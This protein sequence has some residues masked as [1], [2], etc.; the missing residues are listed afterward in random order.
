M[1]RTAILEETGMSYVRISTGGQEEGTSLDTQ[2]LGCLEEAEKLGYYI[3]PENRLREVWSGAELER[4]VLSVARAAARTGRIRALFVHSPD[5]LSR[6]AY[7]ILMLMNEFAEHGVKLHFVRGVSGDTPEGQLITYIQGYAAQQERL[8]IAER[9]LRGKRAAAKEGRMP[10]GT[11]PGLFGYDYDKEHQ[12]RTINEAEAVIVRMMF[13][14]SAE[15]VATYQIGVR[16][17]EKGILTKKGCMWQAAGV[18]RVLNNPAYTGVQPYGQNRYR[19]VKG[20]KR[21]VTPRPPEEEVTLVG[22]SPPIICK[23]LFDRVQESLAIRQ[24]KHTPSKHRYLLTGFAKCIKCG[25]PIVGGALSRNR[26]YYRCRRN[27][28]AVA[29]APIECKAR[30]MYAD[31]MEEVVWRRVSDALKNPEILIAE[32][33]SHFET[34]GGNLGQAM[35]DLRGEILDLKTQQR[36][37]MELWQKDMIDMGLL[38]GQIAPLKSLCDEK[39]QDLR[40]LEEQQ[41]VRDDGAEME[42]RISELCQRFAEK[43]DGMDF[44]EKRATLGAFSVKVLASR[45]ELSISLIVDP[46]VV[47]TEQTWGFS[48][49]LCPEVATQNAG[50][51]GQENPL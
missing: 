42:G 19:K 37:L 23:E 16:L 22:Y 21:V 51:I 36:R 33:R 25:S 49:K 32:L 8:Q 44:E 43:L 46:N 47:T 11:G 29:G 1:D 38:E 41:K 24:S 5:R 26:R 2:E 13:R 6:D 17:N 10:N 28:P 4:P 12:V 48:S 27:V 14:W 31:A 20:N 45:D 3:P 50:V 39:E 9:S 40:V 15:G 34:G 18:R 35:A 30:Y 7:H